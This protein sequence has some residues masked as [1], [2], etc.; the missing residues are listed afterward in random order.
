MDVGSFSKIQGGG[1]QNK[2]FKCNKAI[3]F[4]AFKSG[5]FVTSAMHNLVYNVN[6]SLSG[7]FVIWAQHS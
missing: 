6:E 4:K 7:F 5:V 1:F 3:L 2:P